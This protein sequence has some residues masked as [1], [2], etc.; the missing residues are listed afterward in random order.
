ML[1]NGVLERDTARER[2]WPDQVTETFRLPRKLV[3]NLHTYAQ[4]DMYVEVYT[5]EVIVV[6][7]VVVVVVVSVKEEEDN[8]SHDNSSGDKDINENLREVCG[9]CCQ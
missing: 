3:Q 5:H 4:M 8:S 2:I 1:S 9:K 6:E 7:V